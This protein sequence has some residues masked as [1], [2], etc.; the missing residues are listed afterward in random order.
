[1]QF[2]F[3]WAIIRN[4]AD[5]ICNVPYRRLSQ[6]QIAILRPLEWRNLFGQKSKVVSYEKL[7]KRSAVHFL[8]LFVL[9][10]AKFLAW[11]YGNDQTFLKI[12]ILIFYHHIPW[13]WKI[14]PF[15]PFNFPS[16]N[17]RQ[18][19]FLRPLEWRNLFGHKDKVFSHKKL[20]FRSGCPIFVF[21]CFNGCHFT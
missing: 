16:L 19:V 8:F 17:Q 1:M 18:I 11:D 20:V 12:L 21:V 9:M 7:V 5:W 15:T 3:G 6:G 14:W 4:I 13:Y 2:V 10:D